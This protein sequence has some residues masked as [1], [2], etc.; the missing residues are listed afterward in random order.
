MIDGI[1]ISLRST[2]ETASLPKAA[3]VV[4]TAPL[5]GMFDHRF[6]RLPYRSLR[7]E[8]RHDESWPHSRYGTI[9]LPQDARLIRNC[10]F[11]ILHQQ[12]DR[13]GNWIQ[14]QEPCAADDDHAP[15]YP[16]QT[17]ASEE[18]FARYL[19]LAC[20][21]RNFCPLG[22]LGL[23]KYLDMDAAVALAIRMVPLIE[24]YPDLGHAERFQQLAALRARA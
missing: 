6:G 9:N 7:F 21:S 23:F 18:Q 19:D 24:T 17:P 1:P 4:S 14:Y 22:R 15:M 10:N 11:K 2:A 16:V 3:V 20:R 5:D 12:A 13:P 8:H